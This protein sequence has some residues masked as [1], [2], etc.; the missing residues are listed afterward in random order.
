MANGF[1]ES[2]CIT[3]HTWLFFVQANATNKQVG[4]RQIFDKRCPNIFLKGR[5]DDDHSWRVPR[6]QQLPL[7]KNEKTILIIY[8]HQYV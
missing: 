8:F 6:A 7:M 3:E 2:Y 1:V 4:L 5:V